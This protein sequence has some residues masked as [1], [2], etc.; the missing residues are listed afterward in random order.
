VNAVLAAVAAFAGEVIDEPGVEGIVIGLPRR[1]GGEDS[2]ETAAARAAAR[3]LHERTGL[4]VE[5][6]DERLSSR[7]AESRLATRERDWRKRKAMID[8]VAAAII[9]QDFLDADVRR[10]ERGS[11]LGD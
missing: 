1:L 5:L 4:R 10:L 9:L 6:Q 2:A 3:A 11:P 8:A 7:E